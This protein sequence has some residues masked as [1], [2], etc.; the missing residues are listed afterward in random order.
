MKE[1]H[2]T[3]TKIHRKQIR[4]TKIHRKQITTTKIHRKQIRMTIIHTRI[5]H[6]KLESS[7]KF[8]DLIEL[9]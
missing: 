2:K 6:Y 1:Q 5:H 9:S 8:C 7:F 3:T 4:M